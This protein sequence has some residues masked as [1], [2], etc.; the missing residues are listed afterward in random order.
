MNQAEQA[1]VESNLIGLG[2]IQEVEKFLKV[3]RATIYSLM[4]SGQLSYVKI[5]KSRRI[6]WD[7]V[8]QLILRNTI[9][10]QV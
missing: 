2:R 8:K 7:A 3:S 5:G 9:T 4:E 6:P 1:H 10:A